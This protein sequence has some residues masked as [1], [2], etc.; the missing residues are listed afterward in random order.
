[1]GGR[2]APAGTA[3]HSR[4]CS[5]TSSTPDALWASRSVRLLRPTAVRVIGLHRSVRRQ[6]LL[7]GVN[8][9][10][11][12]GARLLVISNPEG[13]DSLL[14][15]VLAGLVRP[16]HGTFELAGLA[17]ADASSGD[18]GG[19]VAYLPPDGGFYPWLSP[20]EV[21]ELASRLAGHERHERRRRIEAAVDHYRLGAELRMPVSRGGRALAQRVGLAA[22]MLGEPEVLLLNDPL[23]AVD[24]AERARLLQIPGPRRTVVM[25]SRYPAAEDGLV[26]QVALIRDG[27]VALHARTDEL[28]EHDLALSMRGISALADL[29]AVQPAVAATA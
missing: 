19:R 4:R 23:R 7:A 29:R 12:V 13:A 18:W 11:P 26:D 6:R 24:S 25:A 10:V 28:A 15:R 9:R 16:H 5:L 14:L 17:R 3:G 27:R 8:L 22:A 20:G 21:L 1:M 2:L